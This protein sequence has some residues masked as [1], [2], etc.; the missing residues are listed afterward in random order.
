MW[1]LGV[2]CGAESKFYPMISAKAGSASNP[3]AL[4]AATVFERAGR[5]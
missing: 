1:F 5:A 4:A 3:A 2:G